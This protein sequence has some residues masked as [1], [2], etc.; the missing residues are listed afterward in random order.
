[1][2]TV[3]GAG[4]Q[5]EDLRSG[6]VEGGSAGGPGLVLPDAVIESLAG[7]LA[8]RA[9]AGQSVK[10]TG[11]DGLLPG[12]IGQVLAAGLRA[13]P[14][15]TGLEP[16]VH[17]YGIDAYLV[18]S[19]L[20][21]GQTVRHVPVGGVKLHAPSFPHL[22]AIY[23]D[24][25]PVLLAMTPGTAAPTRAPG[26]L[27]YTVEPTHLPADQHTSMAENLRRWRAAAPP[28]TSVTWPLAVTHAWQAVRQARQSPDSAAAMVWPSYLD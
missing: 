7:E 21:A 12:V 3:D 10:L 28:G 19:A 16:R 6:E 22:P 25:A 1:L 20:Q 15:G 11:P 18:A 9:R 8:A 5:V 2:T 24:T 17:G 23:R 14:A 27:K 4:V 13:E 26:P